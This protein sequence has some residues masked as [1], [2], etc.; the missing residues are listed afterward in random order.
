MQ[1]EGFWASRVHSDS[2][3]VNWRTT[4][5]QD[6]LVKPVEDDDW[7]KFVQIVDYPP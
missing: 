2:G 1:W 4:A 3:H 6:C 5:L 7:T